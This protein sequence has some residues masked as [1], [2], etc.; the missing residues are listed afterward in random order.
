M[1]RDDGPLSATHLNP[2]REHLLRYALERREF[3]WKNLY[4]SGYPVNTK[5][6]DEFRQ[7]E[8]LIQLRNAASPEFMQNP[9]AQE[10]LAKLEAKFGPSPSP[11]PMPPPMMAP[12]MEAPMG[13][14][15]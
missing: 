12:P 1:A 7:Y 6:M 4:A 5:P 8:T 13:G 2:R 3:L 10:A 14:M 11:P 15:Q 9:A